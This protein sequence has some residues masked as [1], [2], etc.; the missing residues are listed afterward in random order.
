MVAL[1]YSITKEDYVNFYTYIMWDAPGKRKKRQM[2]YAKQSVPILIFLLAFY[3]TG[4]FDRPGKFILLIGGFLMITTLLSFIGVR[5]NTMKQAESIAENPEN[6]SIFNELNVVASETGLLIK[7]DLKETK[8]Q[9]ASIIKKLESRNYYFLFHNAMEAI[10]I[11]KRAFS[12]EEEKVRF[13]KLLSQYLSLDAEVF[14]L[15]K[16]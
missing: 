12:N 10:I 14:H 8:Y 6:D 7:N 3:Y 15:L 1:K 9:W 13:E 16:R 2:F 5:T 11:P 4:L